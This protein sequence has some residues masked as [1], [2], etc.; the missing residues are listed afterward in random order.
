MRIYEIAASWEELKV[1]FCTCFGIAK[2]ILELFRSCAGVT[3]ISRLDL[4]SF[5][6]ALF[7]FDFHN[8]NTSLI[9]LKL[10]L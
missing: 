1:N 8:L 2:F 10:A 7:S 5:V 9:L 3:Y 4:F 6:S